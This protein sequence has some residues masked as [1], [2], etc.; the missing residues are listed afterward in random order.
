MIKRFNRQ[1]IIFGILQFTAGIVFLLI[2]WVLFMY[3]AG[4]FMV[5][6]PW[7]WE[8]SITAKG[9]ASYIVAIL[10]AVGIR[11]WFV[12]GEQFRVFKDSAFHAALNENPESSLMQEGE[13]YGTG[14][15]DIIGQFIFFGSRQI[16]TAIARIRARLPESADLE[17]RM[18][19]ALKQMRE[20]GK[21]EDVAKY[22][23]Y[24]EE[25][26]ALIRCG[27]VDFSL[28]KLRLKAAG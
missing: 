1:Q 28:S 6:M 20:K 13:D 3:L 15:M 22:S 10:F 19:Y 4:F 21:W 24:A 9:V 5:L 14:V 18:G 27:L 23:D 16:C 17:E 2:A 12:R 7:T 26:G 11:K 8:S 25:V